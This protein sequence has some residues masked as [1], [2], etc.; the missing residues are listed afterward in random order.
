MINK[1]KFLIDINTMNP[2]QEKNSLILRF[3]GIFQGL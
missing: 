1:G 3:S 2:G